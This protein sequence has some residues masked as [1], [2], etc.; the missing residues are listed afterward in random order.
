MEILSFN[1]FKF[2]YKQNTNLF[3][4]Y[5]NI[6]MMLLTTIMMMAMILA[7]M[8]VTKYCRP[9]ISLLGTLIFAPTLLVCACS[10]V[11]LSPWVSPHGDS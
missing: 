2:S 6:L 5:I 1:V 3:S 8:I 10:W 7:M 11:V 9:S 4:T